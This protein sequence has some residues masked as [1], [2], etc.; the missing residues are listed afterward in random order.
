MAVDISIFTAVTLVYLVIVLTLGYL[1]WKKTKQAED[2]M[3]AGRNVHP[4]LIALSYGATFISTSAIVGFGGVAAKLGLG[5]IWLT[6]LNIGVGIMLAFILFGK[7]TRDVGQRLKAVTFPD[8]LGKIY[9]S[10]FMQYAGGLVILVGMPL[11]A[12]A[13]MIGGAR[14]VQQTF[15]IDYTTALLA[16]AAVTAIYVIAGGLLAVIYTDAFQAVIML[17]GMTVLLVFTYMALGGF[18]AANQALTDMASQVPAAL[19]AAGHNGWTAM[20]DLG[21]SIWYT[22]VTTIVLGVGIGVLAQPQLVVRF[23]TAK[24][25][26]A[27]NRAVPIGGIFILMMTGVAFTVGA[28]TNLYFFNETGKI[29]TASVAG[30]N[31]DLIMPAF[32]NMALPDWFVVLFMITLLAA[33]MSTLSS[34]FHTMGTAF[35]HDILKFTKGY[36]ASL[37]KN[38][39]GVILMLVI[40]LG[41]AFLMPESIIARATAMF[42]GLCASAFLPAFAHGLFAKRPSANAAKISLAIGALSWFA[43]TAFVHEAESKPLGI[44]MALTGQGALLGQPWTVIDPLIIALPLATIA[45]VIVWA[46]EAYSSS[47]K[48]KAQKGAAE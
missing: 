9:N 21:S 3:V 8:L 10:K 23:M 27:L 28:L 46:I 40:S 18:T 19:T 31:V 47:Q 41:L 1:G 48:A 16:F 44:S 11:Y 45:L 6:A 42:M 26:R 38:R 32:I 34:L 37:N 22:L 43:Y 33:A 24:D 13:V 12:S 35:G 2:Y 36:K 25:D 20:P 4:A 15:G 5:L 7:R 29:A 39:I 17:V 30:G 14:F